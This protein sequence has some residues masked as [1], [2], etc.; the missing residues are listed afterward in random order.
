[1]R[2]I[3][4]V[5]ERNRFFAHLENLFLR[6]LVNER[7]HIRELSFGKIT[8]ARKLAFKTESIK[9]FQPPKI[10]FQVID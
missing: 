9:S 10:N 4:P 7:K 3:N 5:I 1:M 2:V 6:M 8:K